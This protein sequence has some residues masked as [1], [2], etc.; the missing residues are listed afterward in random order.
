MQCKVSRN[1]AIAEH[2]CVKADKIE[3]VQEKFYRYAALP[4]LFQGIK[5]KANNA[6]YINLIGSDFVQE[7]AH[8]SPVAPVGVVLQ[9]PKY[10]MSI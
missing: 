1:F 8:N 3:A 10:F 6:V 2:S 9:M 4:D 5:A 7:L